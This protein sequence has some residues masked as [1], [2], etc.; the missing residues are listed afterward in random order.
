MEKFFLLMRGF[1]RARSLTAKIR[2]RIYQGW[3]L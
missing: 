1:C 2:I 3:Y